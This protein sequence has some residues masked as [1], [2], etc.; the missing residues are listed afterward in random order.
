MLGPL[1]FILYVN[2]ITDGL[3][4]MLEMFANDS[5]LSKQLEIQRFYRKISIL[6]LTGLDF[7]Y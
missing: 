5:K 2:D 3:H 1:L 6:S 4:S 7:G